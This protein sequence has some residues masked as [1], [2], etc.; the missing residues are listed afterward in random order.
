MDKIDKEK[1]IDILQKTQN[2]FF[3]YI[4]GSRIKNKT[5]FG[6][7]LDIALFFKNEPKLEDL[8]RL[9]LELEEIANSKVDLISLNNLYLK[10]PKLAYSVI[11]E[12]VLLFCLDDK[13][14]SHFKKM[15]YLTYLDFK[16]IID[17]FNRKLIER[18][19]NNKF[20]VVQK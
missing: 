6:S 8:G 12:G 2:V 5:R 13:L 7:D 16:N 10:N 14:L 1:I 9:V 17:L 3:A 19:S 15:T 18:I 4:F 11:G 20:A